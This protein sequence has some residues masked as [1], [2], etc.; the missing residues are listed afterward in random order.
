MRHRASDLARAAREKARSRGPARGTTKT[1]SAEAAA[2]IEAT[3][4]T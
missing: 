4:K 1:P 3:H 2:V